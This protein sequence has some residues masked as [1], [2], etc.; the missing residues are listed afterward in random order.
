MH[1]DAGRARVRLVQVHTC[2][3]VAARASCGTTSCCMG[4]VIEPHCLRL[5]IRNSRTC[6]AGECIVDIVVVVVVAPWMMRSASRRRQYVHVYVYVYLCT[7]DGTR[8]KQGTLAIGQIR[9][10]AFY[11]SDIMLSARRTPCLRC[12]LDNYLALA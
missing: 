6:V 7:F 12:A 8:V 5:L 3:C 11:N 1:E 4:V 2:A 9:R 10:K